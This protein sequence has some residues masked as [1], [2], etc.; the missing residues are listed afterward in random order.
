MADRSLTPDE[1]VLHRLINRTRTTKDL[2]DGLERLSSEQRTLAKKSLPVLRS[3]TAFGLQYRCIVLAAF[4]DATPEQVATT[5]SEWSVKLLVR[6]HLTRSQVVERLT[7]R[8]EEWVREFVAAALRKVSLTE[9]LP[10]LLDPL[11]NTFELPLPTDSRYWLGWMRNHPAPAHHCRWE[12]RFIAACAA[13][14]AFVIPHGDRTTYV[15]TVVRCARN[16]RAAEPTDDPAL[17]RALLQIFDRGDRI[18][19]QRVAMLWLEGLGLIPLLP[20]ERKRVI[21]ALPNAGGAFAKLAI[22][23]LLAADLSDAD[24]TDL[25]LAILP[26]SEKGLKRTVAK[27]AIR[28]TAPSQNLLDTVQ[29][30]ASDQDTTSAALA[31]NLLDH[32]NGTTTGKPENAGQPQPSHGGGPVPDTPRPRARDAGTLGLWRTPAGRCPQLL[33]DHTDA[34]LVLD[35]PGLAALITKVDADRRC[36]PDLQ[37]HALAALVATAHARGPIRVKHAIRTGIRYTNPHSS[38]LAQLLERLGK[39]GDGELRQPMMME[40]WPLT[41][42]PVQR[43]IDVLGRL[44]EL[45]CLL[46]T[47]THTGFSITWKVFTRR[48]RRYREAD[49]AVL[50]TDVAVA[51]ARLDRSKAPDDLSAFEQPIHGVTADLA[52]VIA[53]W[54]DHPARPGELRGLTAR[55]EQDHDPPFRRLEVDGDEPTSHE[56]LGIHSHWSLPYQPIYAHQED[57][58]VFV[59]LPEHPAR[60]AGLVLYASKTFALSIFERIATTIPR[61]GPVASFVSLALASDTTTKNRDRAAALLLTAWDEE[62]LTADDLISAWRSPWRGIREFSA[63]RVTETLGRIADGGGLALTW[64]LLT[65]MAEEIAGQEK[66]PA[67]AST[68][69]ESLLHY[70]PEARAAGIPVDL[71]NIMALANQEA[72][73]KAVR[74]AKLI[75]SQ[76]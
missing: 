13:P 18:G 43:A 69:L 37:E 4:L 22:K 33:R 42:L 6:D 31:R 14:N 11:I 32:W 75:V 58:W 23:Q 45:P 64:P 53:H 61:F 54:R 66:I 74:V 62:R 17:L 76:L 67:P 40:S 20:T 9:H 65:T 7:A 48:A 70:L 25:T 29:L 10:P 71:P 59:T 2:L 73:T 30:I 44:G 3:R 19:G 24:L 68:V 34:A 60:P 1:L 21:A 15:D 38:V 52:A 16:L 12:K 50:P 28:L 51:L 63:P 46:S 36:D 26:R 5:L 39:R 55:D 27:A 35:D 49:L 72:P 47:P 56:L 57:P 41:F 8:G